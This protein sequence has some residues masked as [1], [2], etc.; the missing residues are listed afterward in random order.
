M[1]ALVPQNFGPVSTRFQAAGV[2][3]DLAGGI[4]TSYG[5]VGFKGKVWSIRHRGDERPLLREDGDGPRNSIEVVVV[6]ANGHLSKIFYENGYVEG[7]SAPPDCFSNNGVT[8]EAS[9]AKKQANAC[10]TCPRNAWGSRITPA[11]KQGKACADSKRVAVVPLG[12]LNNETFGGPM[13]LRIPAA[14]LNDL[15]AY[16]T[17]MQQLGY[18]Y[19]AIGTRIAFDAA[20]AYPKFVFSAIRPLNDAEA[21][22]VLALQS[23]PH[24][25][26]VL[27]EDAELP[28]AAPPV[29]AA[30][31]FEQ[32]P[33]VAP[34][35]QQA[36]VQQA[37]VQ[38]TAPL[39]PH[40]PETGEVLPE[41][42]KPKRAYQRRPAAAAAPAAAP[43]A[44]PAAPVA[45]EPAAPQSFEDE[46]DAQLDGL[47]G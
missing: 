14:S 36:P 31:A 37:P 38:Q 35:V 17:K 10:A 46:L 21:D 2:E 7:S 45:P 22:A 6:K 34:P 11:G 28:P 1:N 9:S 12:D 30:S 39:P 43:E 33:Q 25:A 16:G 13:L 3:N 20:E 24:V 29:T 23:G 42:V 47:L 4:A 27:S 40:N 8:P 41:P 32:P 19:F 26:R 18:P 44:T 15:A 5:I